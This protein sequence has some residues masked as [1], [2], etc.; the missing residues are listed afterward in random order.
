MHRNGEHLNIGPTGTATDIA[1]F[2]TVLNAVLASNLDIKTVGKDAFFKDAEVQ[3]FGEHC[4]RF[5]LYA[6]QI[7]KCGDPLCQVKDCGPTKLPPAEFNARVHWFPSPMKRPVLVDTLDLTGD[8]D[9]SPWYDFEEV[10]GKM[11]TTEG[12]RPSLHKTEASKA[13]TATDKAEKKTFIKAAIQGL[14]RCSVCGKNR[15]MF[16]RHEALKEGTMLTEAEKSL[17]TDVAELNPY[18]C[19]AP[20]FGGDL[21]HPLAQKVHTSYT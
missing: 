9:R 5:T 17:L 2:E 7:K 1:M 20:L 18:T 10:Y 14:I 11:E 6:F 13:A 4:C 15:A 19:R 12:D 16:F 8:E 21:D 3:I